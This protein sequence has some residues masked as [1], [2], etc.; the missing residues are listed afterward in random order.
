MPLSKGV[1]RDSRQSCL[2]PFCSCDENTGLERERRRCLFSKNI[3]E[4]S[5]LKELN[6]RGSGNGIRRLSYGGDVFLRI[7]K[8]FDEHGERSGT[9]IKQEAKAAWV[10]FGQAIHR[11]ADGS[12]APS[13][14]ARFNST[15]LR[16]RA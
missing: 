3:N 6:E 7:C 5:M 2:P 8:A 11:P 15:L 10:A 16:S 4:E 13:P 12:R 14:P 9:R 1:R